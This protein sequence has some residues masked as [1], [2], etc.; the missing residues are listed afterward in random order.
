MLASWRGGLLAFNSRAVVFK[1]DALGRQ[2]GGQCSVIFIQYLRLNRYEPGVPAAFSCRRT[3]LMS[4]PDHHMHTSSHTHR[5]GCLVSVSDE[6]RCGCTKINAS[7]RPSSPSSVPFEVLFET[8]DGRIVRCGGHWAA[9]DCF[10]DNGA[11]VPFFHM[12]RGAVFTQPSIQK[13]E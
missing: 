8:L 9:G 3:W 7:P 11:F 4:G 5:R 6:G 12:C 10:D 1:R 13:A 2:Q